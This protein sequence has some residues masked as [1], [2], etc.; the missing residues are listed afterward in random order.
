MA[1]TNE[2]ELEEEIVR[3]GLAAPRLTPADIDAQILVEQYHRF[4]GST[5]TVCVLTLRNGF[6]VVGESAAASAA[7]YDEAIG[8]R[9]ARV[10][11][12]SKIWALEGYLLRSKLA[13]MEANRSDEVTLA[14]VARVAHEVNRGYCDSIGDHSQKPW[15]E[16]P[17]WQKQSAIA[18]VKFVKANPHAGPAASHE[19][20]LAEKREAGWKYGPVKNVETKEH[21][22][23]V[24]YSELPLEQRV[25]DYLFQAT[26]RALV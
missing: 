23:F 11:A 26:V 25:K 15:N 19:A 7:N 20:W 8:K 12:R 14:G 13:G 24:P 16:A 17:D 18:G 5:L 22:C 21:P 2:L 10:N 4:P 1:T 3:K 9:I 6:M